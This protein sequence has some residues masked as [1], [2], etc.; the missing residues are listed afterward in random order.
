MKYKVLDVDSIISL[1]NEVVD[2]EKNDVLALLFGGQNDEY[3]FHKIGF[4]YHHLHE[5]L[6]EFGFCDIEKVE[7]FGFFQVFMVLVLVLVLVICF[8]SKTSTT[9]SFL[10]ITHI[11]LYIFIIFT[12][13]SFSLFL[14][15]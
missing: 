7:Y 3:N 15:F 2:D 5:I 6:V 14:S 9:S 10:S 8:S 12:Q 13:I 4:H 1:Y 11:E